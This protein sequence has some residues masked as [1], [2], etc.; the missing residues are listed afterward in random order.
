MFSFKHNSIMITNIF[1]LIWVMQ[2]NGVPT[3][4]GVQHSADNIERMYSFINKYPFDSLLLI[5][6]IL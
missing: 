3:T 5:C 4:S 6:K 1:I 2:A